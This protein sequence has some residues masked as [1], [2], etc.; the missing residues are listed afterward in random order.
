M[1]KI[2]TFGIMLLFIGL[3]I[4]SST[5]FNLDNLPPP[6]ITGPTNG[7]VGVE[8]KYKFNSTVPPEYHVRYFI[9]W[10][11]NKTEWSEWNPY[12]NN[13]TLNHSWDTKGTYIIRARIYDAYGGKS[14]WG[15][16]EVTM[17]KNYN[18]L[19]MQRAGRF[20]L[21]NQFILRMMERWNI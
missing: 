12:G 21:L 18:V 16:L 3:I 4:S 17:P 11:D 5:A 8:Y 2:L 13:I 14:P 7:R 15:Y 6:I 20:P 9:D 19:F 10:G 1:K